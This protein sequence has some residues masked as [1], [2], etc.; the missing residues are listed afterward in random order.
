[1]LLQVCTPEK[2]ID[3]MKLNELR[4]VLKTNTSLATETASRTINNNN[5]NSNSTKMPKVRFA[6]VAETG[7]LNSFLDPYKVPTN[8]PTTAVNGSNQQT[9]SPYGGSGTSSGMMLLSSASSANTNSSSPPDENTQLM[10][11]RKGHLKKLRTYSC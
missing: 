7:S 10:K 2:V 9:P 4:R 1:M 3:L 11:S 6:S 8:T 5:N